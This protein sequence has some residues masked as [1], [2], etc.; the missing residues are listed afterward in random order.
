[1][2]IQDLNLG[3]LNPKCEF[4]KNKMTIFGTK[5]KVKSKCIW[6]NVN[7][8]MLL[9]FSLI[10]V[11]KG[12]SKYFVVSEKEFIGKTCKIENGKQDKVLEQ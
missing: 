4:K 10:V 3:N 7:K 5:I 11:W 12:L 2:R 1:M 6:N 8:T 9:W